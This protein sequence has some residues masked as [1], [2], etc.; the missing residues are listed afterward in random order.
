[1]LV[2]AA[3]NGEIFFFETNG[4]SNLELYEPLCMLRLPENSQ[5]NDLKW[6]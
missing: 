2:T 6:D 4:H 3:R 1:M 5:I